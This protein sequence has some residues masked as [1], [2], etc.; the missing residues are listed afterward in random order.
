MRK[1]DRFTKPYFETRG[2]K[3]VGVYEIVRHK[4][5]ESIL[6]EEKFNSLKEARM[7]IYQY[8]HNNLEWLNVNSDISEFNFKDNRDEKDNKWHDNAIE[9]VYK[10][11]YKDLKDWKK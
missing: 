8:A 10:K 1:L 5:N 7:F 11:E 4:S 9:K 6:F 2:E 3:E